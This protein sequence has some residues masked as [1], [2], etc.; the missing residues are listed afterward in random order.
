[1]K[2][3]PASPCTPTTPSNFLSGKR[4][5]VQARNDVL[6][7]PSVF[8]A[9]P[10]LEHGAG[11]EAAWRFRAPLAKGLAIRAPPESGKEKVLWG[12][13]RGG[14]TF[15]KFLFEYTVIQ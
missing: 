2:I 13:V 15:S 6:E 14:R 9:C 3:F 12:G 10:V 7:Q 8:E 4:K 1:M 5:A 11:M